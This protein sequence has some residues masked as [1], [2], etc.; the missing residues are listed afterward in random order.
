MKPEF[1]ARAEGD[2]RATGQSFRQQRVV[3]HIDERDQAIP[4]RLFSGDGEML[5]AKFLPS[6]QRWRCDRSRSVSGA[7]GQRKR[8]WPLRNKRIM[9]GHGKPAGYAT[10]KAAIAAE[11]EDAAQG[12]CKACSWLGGPQV[13]CS[14]NR[15][16][17]SGFPAAR[18]A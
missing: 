7:A 6:R 5:A 13:S 10:A 12:R 8:S 15:W 2:G 11:D 17:R 4:Y 14:P 16:Y 9:P 18:P 3:R 1:S